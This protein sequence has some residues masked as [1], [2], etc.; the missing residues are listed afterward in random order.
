M[1]FYE[2]DQIIR[3]N[4]N[5]KIVAEHIVRNNIDLNEFLNRTLVSLN[6]SEEQPQQPGFFQRIKQNVSNMWN[7]F[8]GN[9]YDV[10]SVTQILQ[11]VHEFLNGNPEMQKKYGEEINSLANIVKSIGTKTTG[12]P[13][14][15]KP[16]EAETTSKPDASKPADPETK[17]GEGAD[18]NLVEAYLKRLTY[19]QSVDV[20]KTRPNE[21]Y[22]F[23][24]QELAGYPQQNDIENVKNK[25]MKD[26][27]E[28]IAHL[29]KTGVSYS[30]TDKFNLTEWD[31]WSKI[32]D[33]LS[34]ETW[35]LWN[36]GKQLYFGKNPS[37]SGEGYKLGNPITDDNIQ[38]N[39]VNGMVGFAVTAG[40]NPISR[41]KLSSKDLI[42]VGEKALSEKPLFNAKPE[43]PVE[44]TPTTGTAPPPTAT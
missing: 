3:E 5:Y 17:T 1:R 2:L 11:K 28:K 14:H 38:Q 16:A 26:L 44:T 34:H 35:A 32:K 36:I 41:Q 39:I 23:Y 20:L 8:R 19:G 12:S 37:K 9:P 4:K 31:S 18:P 25:L 43:P 40:V 10:G 7:K 27:N 13:D 33:I 24:A 30:G 29:E 15:S 22:K 21:N 42:T 6:E